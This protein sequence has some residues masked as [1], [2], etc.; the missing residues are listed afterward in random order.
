M[1]INADTVIVRSDT[2]STGEI[3]GEIV[4][5][6]VEQGQ[7]FGL[8]PIGAAVWKL[9]EQPVALGRIVD[10]LTGE[11]EVDRDQ[12]LADLQS[13]VAELADI[14]MVRIVDS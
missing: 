3:D 4:A 11:Y 6:D 14:G 9:A 12:C 2:L 8:D 7:C 13:F 1:K 5:L 10:K